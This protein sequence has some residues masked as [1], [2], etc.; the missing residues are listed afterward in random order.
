MR[1][2]Q[3]DDFGRTL[4]TLRYGLLYDSDRV[5]VPRWQSTPVEGTPLAS[6]HEIR[7]VAIT[8][9]MP[10]SLTMAQKDIQP[11][12]PWAEDHF[13]ERIGGKP[14]NPG[15]EYKN[16][17]WFRGNVA[18]HQ[19]QGEAAFSHTY[20]ERYWPKMANVGG[21]RPNGRQVFVPHNGIRF[22]YGDLFDVVEQLHLDPYT[23]QA[24]LPVWFPEDTG[25]V[26]GERVPC[27]LG[28]HFMIRPGRLY[29]GDLL[30]CNYFIRSCDFVRHFRDDVYLAVRLA[31][32]MTVQL[33]VRKPR[34]TQDHVQPGELT[35]FMGSLH[36][37]DGDVDKLKREMVNSGT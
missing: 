27:T 12:L 18:K 8:Y 25:V 17:P 34:Q 6:T 16:W 11:N 29:R 7:N 19:T 35:M 30:H 24:Y 32:W 37:F 28:Y 22:E 9:D 20:M 5:E 3:A 36:I 33:A 13:Q 10:M 14:L 26:H 15:E 4:S 2:I 21:V 1:A 31:Q 23:R